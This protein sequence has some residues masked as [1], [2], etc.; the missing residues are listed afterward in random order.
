MVAAHI[1]VF[2]DSCQFV[3]RSNYT[4]PWRTA[5][6]FFSGI[7]L[8]SLS[9]SAGCVLAGAWPVLPFAGLELGA[10]GAALYVTGRRARLREVIT[11]HGGV[12]EV[13]RGHGR[14][15]HSHRFQRGWA[16]VQLEHAGIE[17]HPARLVISSHGR[18]IEI[19]HQLTESERR[20]LAREL[21]GQLASGGGA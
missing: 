11:I 9:I 5:V 12:V 6:T 7:S 4:F 21:A 8:V 1:D 17:G 10:L 2:G 13:Q 16:R 3:L 20:Q 15:A 19:G 18:Q 14:P